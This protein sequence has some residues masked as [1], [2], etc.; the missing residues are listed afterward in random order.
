MER[1]REDVT[2]GRHREKWGPEEAEGWEGKGGNRRRG[3][4]GVAQDP[5]G[6]RLPAGRLGSE[7]GSCDLGTRPVATCV[8]LGTLPEIAG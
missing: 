3:C 7:S 2:R 1:F 6:M 4:L 8:A 5:P